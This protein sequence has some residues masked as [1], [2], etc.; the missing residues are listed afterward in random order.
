METDISDFFPELQTYSSELYHVMIAVASLILLAGLIIRIN[1]SGG[2]P[3]L[4]VRA[5][6]TVGIAGILISALP[7]W[8]NQLQVIAYDLIDGMGADP[9]KSYQRFAKLMVKTSPNSGGDP[10]IWDILWGEGGGLGDAMVYAALFLTSKLAQAIMFLFFIVQ[11]TL[12][13]F[14]TALA[15]AF[16]AMFMIRSLSGTATQFFL[17]LVAVCLWPIGWAIASLMTNALIEMS[18]HDDGQIVDYYQGNG[19]ILILSLWILLST[20]AAPL[21]IWKLLSGA[22]SAG[23]A[24]FGG[25][26]SG[27]SQGAA[28]AASGGMTTVM[29]GGS[30]LATAAG[31]TAGGIGGAVSGALG[32]GGGVI[33]PT[34]IG[35]GSAMVA[36]NSADSG[37]VDY[38]RRAA[39]LSN[40]K[41]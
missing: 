41:S 31:A 20:L 35:L 19:F 5:V 40:G 2:D 17:R 13:L 38:N 25:V 8:I 6:L 29:M 23:D 16:V 15:P 14:Q 22:S 27:L 36:G 37:P 34:A 39:E 26:A 32:A 1:A 11:Q 7:D 9:S 4:M 28:F 24:L 33:I 30:S 21:V 3:I 12:V 18:T 10:G